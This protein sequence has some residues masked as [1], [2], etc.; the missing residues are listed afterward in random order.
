MNKDNSERIEDKAL[1]TEMKKS[2]LEY[3][4]SVIVGRALPDARDG[5]KPVHRRIL[6]AMKEMGSGSRAAYKKSARIVGDVMGKYHPHGDQAIYDS[7]VRMAQSFSLRYPLVDGQGNF[8]SVDGDRAAAMRYTESRLTPIA[9]IVLQDL[10]KKTIDYGENYDGSLKEPSVLPS[11]LPNLL[12]NGSEGIAVGMATKMAP[13]N[14]S[15]VIDAII[16][17]MENPRVNTSELIQVIPGPDFPTGGVIMGRAGVFEAYSNGRGS[18]KIRGRTNIEE[19]KKTTQIVI[20]EI[21]Y[22]LEKNRLLR[23]IT[24]LVKN[25]KIEGIR[26]L[27]D[28]SNRKG[29]RIIVELKRDASAVIIE[30]LLYKHSSL[31][32]TFA[33]NNTALVNGQPQ[34]L[35]LKELLK[36]YI[37]HR[38]KVVTRRTKFQLK[39]AKDRAHIVEGLLIA[40]NKMNQVISFIRSANNRKNVIDGLKTQFKLSSKQAEAIAEMRL[41]QLSKQD[42]DA[43]ENELKELNKEIAELDATLADP[44]RIRSIIKKELE[45]LKEKYG[46]ERRTEISE[47]EGEIE[48]EDLIPQQEV[49]VMRTDESYVKR[50]ALE[51]FRIQHR[52]GTGMIGIKAKEGDIPVEM[53]SMNSHDHILLFTSEGSMYFLKGWQ[54]PDVSRYAKGTPIVQLLEKL[55]ERRHQNDEK[56]LNMLPVPNISSPDNYLIFAT[57]NGIVKKTRIEEYASRVE[58]AWRSDQGFRAITLKEGDELIS[59]GI[60]DGESEIMLATN[61]GMANRFPENQVRVVGRAGQGVI[62]IRLKEGDGVKSMAIVNEEEELLTITEMG[63]GKRAKAGNYRLTRR[64]SKGVINTKTEKYGK[65]VSS[66]SVGESDMIMA[67]TSSGK[68]INTN[69]NELREMKRIGRGSRLIKLK[70]EEKVVAVAVYLKIEEDDTEIEAK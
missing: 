5:L 35:S 57:K 25:K 24:D 54:I 59:V 30:N 34:R 42:R 31:E 2:Y 1:T 11:M 20:T 21:P 23:E 36:V 40:I 69:I 33:V 26:D 9:E 62:G 28:E 67:T 16:L 48:T 60:S 12:V 58:R 44:N 39:I 17:T 51:E 7:M 41:Y 45:M 15:E 55:D 66:I 70:D 8:G 49:V 47:H 14:L 27:R 64:G 50:M 4:M 29:M 63:W 65:V 56:I 13:H 53:H 68:V 22:S 43:R 10:K 38:K 52:G 19:T 3:A 37:D 6:Y 32:S 18:I 46:D 61:D